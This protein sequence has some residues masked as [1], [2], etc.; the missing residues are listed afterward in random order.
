[1]EGLAWQRCW[2]RAELSAEDRGTEGA[3]CAEHQSPIV[4]SESRLGVT[5]LGAGLLGHVVAPGKSRV[6][7]Q[8]LHGASKPGAIMGTPAV[9]GR[10]APTECVPQGTQSCRD[11]GG[12]LL[13]GKMAVRSRSAQPGV[14]GRHD[15]GHT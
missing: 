8:R 1:M 4:F 7:R 2:I 11:A 15:S 6:A 14:R 3:M 5:S 9:P 10:G 13:V 12:P